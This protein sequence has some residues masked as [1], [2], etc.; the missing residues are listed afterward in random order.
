MLSKII[1]N[2]G[3]G[4]VQATFDNLS[5]SVAATKARAVTQADLDAG[6]N[7]VSIFGNNQV[8]ITTSTANLYGKALSV[9]DELD[10]KGKPILVTVQVG[11]IADMNGTTTLPTAGIRVVQ[12]GGKVAA[13]AASTGRGQVTTVYST[14][15]IEIDLGA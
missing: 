7:A 9:S 12:Q 13:S 15:H 1:M 11:G 14:D 3:I 4:L 6:R 10:S 8:G 2:S 5:T